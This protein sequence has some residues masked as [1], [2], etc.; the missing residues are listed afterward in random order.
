MLYELT[1]LTVKKFVIIMTCEDGECEVYEE[2]DKS[3]SILDSLLSISESSLNSN[4]NQML[5]KIKTL[6]NSWR[7]SSTAPRKFSEEIE[8]IHS[9]NSGMSYIDSIVFFCEKNNIDVE[10]V[11]KLISK[12]LKEKIKCEEPLN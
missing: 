1:G 9:D 2:Y 11:P 8:K 10:S 3:L 12:P 7:V 6:I 5:L 4:Y